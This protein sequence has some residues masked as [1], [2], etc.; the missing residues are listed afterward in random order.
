MKLK[1]SLIFSFQNWRLKIFIIDD[2][3]NCVIIKN[4]EEDNIDEVLML[5]ENEKRSGGGPIE[6]HEYDKSRNCLVLYFENPEIV[7]R[8]IKFGPVILKSKKYVAENKISSINNDN[9]DVI[10]QVENQIMIKEVT[11]NELEHVLLLFENEKRSGGGLIKSHNFINELNVLIIEFLNP[12]CAT[13][14]IKFGTVN[15]RERCYKAQK[16]EQ[17]IITSLKNNL[18]NEYDNFKFKI[19]IHK[20]DLKDMIDVKQEMLELYI[21]FL[22]ESK[23][24]YFQLNYGLD[25]ELFKN[26]L[27]YIVASEKPISYN[28]IQMKNKKKPELI[29]RKVSTQQ[30]KENGC[31]I[32][33]TKQHADI[34][35]LYFQNQRKSGGGEIKRF[36]KH[37]NFYL[38]QFADTSCVNRVLSNSPRNDMKV[39]RFYDDINEFVDKMNMFK[40]KEVA[41][42]LNIDTNEFPFSYVVN[43]QKEI[44]KLKVLLIK[45]G[46]KLTSESGKLQIQYYLS[47]ILKNKLDEQIT[48]FK[49]CFMAHEWTVESDIFFKLESNLKNL[50][51]DQI[52]L[53]LSF[54]D[55]VGAKNIR[56]EGLADPVKNEI[57]KI[58]FILNENKKA[59][60]KITNLKP[61]QCSL[62]L[63]SGF[64]ATSKKMNQDI[65]IKIAP[66]IGTVTFN[67]FTKSISNCVKKMWDMIN[68]IVLK[69]SEIAYLIGKF[70]STSRDYVERLFEEKTIKCEFEV[71]IENDGQILGDKDI[72]FEKCKLNFY[73]L[74]VTELNKAYTFINENI[75]Q[76]KLDLLA[77]SID[78]LDKLYPQFLEKKRDELKLSKEHDQVIFVS[79][80]SNKKV[81][82]VGN[83]LLVNHLSKQINDFFEANTMLSKYCDDFN[84][85]DLRYLN[86]V[87]NEEIPKIC[88]NLHRETN[89]LIAANFEA[90][91]Y[92]DP[93][94]I[95]K[96][97]M[98]GTKKMLERLVRELRNIISKQI[99]VIIELTDESV[100]DLFL[101]ERGRRTLNIIESQTQ[102]LIIHTNEVTK[103]EIEK[104]DINSSKESRSTSTVECT[105]EENICDVK[106]KVVKNRLDKFDL[107]EVIV[108]GAQSDP[109]HYPNNLEPFNDISKSIIKNHGTELIN[110]INNIKE[111]N[112]DIFEG[113]TFAVKLK[114]KRSVVLAVVPKEINSTE[115]NFF[116]D[117]IKQSLEKTS[118]EFS[119]IAFPIFY[120]NKPENETQLVI[121]T[122]VNT[123]VSYLFNNNNLKLKEIFIVDEKYV[124]SIEKSIKQAKKNM[125]LIIRLKHQVQKMGA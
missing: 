107:A 22:V 115:V 90:V 32:V 65:I 76:F 4:V 66:P 100:K 78:L 28:D 30:I 71:I 98:T 72:S 88:I 15:I 12:E 9:V 33:Y 81:W 13:R 120:T 24:K 10:E 122:L 56:I 63:N 116:K 105:S 117:C 6:R 36:E 68:Q 102:C 121:D 67:G 49:K 87:K 41:E 11:K 14:A 64:I 7:K 39:E 61:Y 94:G 3:S 91:N 59:E 46:A 124:D 70:I 43:N 74:N 50:Y 17:S 106:L 51:K 110:E 57:V 40:K 42:I 93:N 21:E 1:V 113:Y 92:Q 85:N 84:N 123:L 109:N 69:E 77:D 5:F 31:V 125:N 58:D 96:L 118:K 34:V 27:E 79:S 111:N 86:I 45:H 19:L 26:T 18:A 73:A 47:K 44:E 103:L 101:N 48:E 97:R 23:F 54:H 62:L 16:F 25:E 38:I 20:N 8:V 99:T 82:C 2:E 112:K 104:K 29:D 108:I 80:K 83:K 37:E 89:C 114:E 52:D 60:E 53:Y 55:V 75:T 119:T 95:I 35:E